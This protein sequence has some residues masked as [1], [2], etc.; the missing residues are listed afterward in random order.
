MSMKIGQKVTLVSRRGRYATTLKTISSDGSVDYAV[1]EIA[2][3]TGSTREVK[4]TELPALV[5]PELQAYDEQTANAKL[6]EIVG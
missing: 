6:A 3:L 1:L 5:A 4:L 2:G